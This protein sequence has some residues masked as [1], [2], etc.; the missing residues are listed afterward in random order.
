MSDDKYVVSI[1]RQLGSGGREIGERLA[2][3]LR[4]GYFD[5]QLLIN[6]LLS[7]NKNTKLNII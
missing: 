1:G 5:R 7:I 2:Q 4:I 3:V 6:S